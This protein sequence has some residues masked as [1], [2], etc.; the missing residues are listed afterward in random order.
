MKTMTAI[1]K[2]IST[3]R[4]AGSHLSTS[5]SLFHANFNPQQVLGSAA[6]TDTSRH[7]SITDERT[8]Q[9]LVIPHQCLLVMQ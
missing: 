2:M 7:K 4:I 9:D 1:L 8:W 5:S 3:M 6:T